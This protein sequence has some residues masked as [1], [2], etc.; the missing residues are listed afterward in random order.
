ARGWQVID[1]PAGAAAQTLA[2]DTVEGRQRLYAAIYRTG[3]LTTQTG[4]ALWAIDLNQLSFRS[5]AAFDPANSSVRGIAVRPDSGLFATGLSTGGLRHTTPSG[6]TGALELDRR[7]VPAVEAAEGMTFAA[8]T[9]Q[10]TDDAAGLVSGAAAVWRRNGDEAFAPLSNSGQP[11]GS[12]Y[13]WDLAIDANGRLWASMDGNGIYSLDGATGLRPASQGWR[14]VKD[15]ELGGQTAKALAVDPVDAHDVYAGLGRS[16]TKP[17]TSIDGRFGLRISW[18]GGAEWTSYPFSS[19]LGERLGGGTPF[20]DFEVPSVAVGPA[21]GLV[22]ASVWGDSL[23]F[24]KDAGH[25]WHRLRLPRG[26]TPYFDA[27]ATARVSATCDL[28]FASGKDGL[29]VRSVADVMAEVARTIYLPAI[30][31]APWELNWPASAP[32]PAPRDG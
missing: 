32:R 18:D 16:A 25:Q 1:L 17:R 5:F 19:T 13:F 24:S 31:G 6:T 3:G 10:V 29:W 7:L 28:V 23:Y 15:L 11:F 21:G 12:G 14:A 9:D 4:S 2:V 22:W 26:A 27:L 30:H 8:A 20:R